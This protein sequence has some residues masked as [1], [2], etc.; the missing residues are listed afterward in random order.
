MTRRALK[1]TLFQTIVMLTV[2]SAF[3]TSSRDAMGESFTRR[4]VR[5]GAVTGIELGIEGAMEVTS[6]GRLRWL[7]TLYDIVGHDELRPATGGELRVLV[8]YRPDEPVAELQTDAYGRAQVE[9]DVPD[10]RRSGFNVVVQAVSRAG[11]QRHFGVQVTT[12]PPRHVELYVDRDAVAPSERMTFFGRVLTLPGARPLAS[13]EVR[14][15]VADERGRP[16]QAERTVRTGPAGGFALVLRA[17]DDVGTL[18]VTARLDHG[19]SAVAS[20]VVRDVLPPEMVVT[21]APERGL[22]S[23]GRAVPVDVVVRRADGR[24]VVGA[25]ISLPGAPDT[26]RPPGAAPEPM[27]RTNAAGRVRIMWR[28]PA[29]SGTAALE[30]VTGRVSATHPGL[31]Q[32]VTEVSVR[33]VRSAFD[34]GLA[35]EGGTLIPGLPGRVFVRVVSADGTA[36]PEGIPVQFNSELLGEH[37]AETD[38]SGVAVIEATA[39]VRPGLAGRDRCGGTTASAITVRVGNGAESA[40]LERCLPVDPD[41]TIRVRLGSAVVVAGGAVEATLTRAARVARAPTLITLLRRRGENL[42]PLYQ[43]VVPSSTSQIE[44]T[45]PEDVVGEVVVRARPLVGA[46]R[47]EVR[48]GSALVWSTPGPRFA[49]DVTVARPPHQVSVA[50]VGSSD[51]ARRGVVLVLRQGEAEAEELFARLREAWDPLART[52][53]D[54]SRASGPMLLGL[55]AA[56]TPRDVAAPA[57]IRGRDV[58]TLPAPESP[59]AEGVLRDPW[60]ARARFVRGRLGLVMRALELYHASCIPDDVSNVGAQEGRG[61]T[62]NREVLEA[63]SSSPVLGASGARALSGAPLTIEDLETLDSSFTFNNMARRITR[64]R[65]L[66]VLVALREFVRDN[67]LDLRWGSQGDPALWLPQVVDHLDVEYDPN[68]DTG[69]RDLL[70]DG[71]GRPMAIRRAAGGRTRFQFLTPLPPGYELVSA[72]P[73]GRFGTAD[74]VFDPFARVLASGG[75]YAEAVA[76][77]DLLA[78]LNGVEL[79]QATIDQLAEVFSVPIDSVLEGAELSVSELSWTDLPELLPLRQDLDFF[80]RGWAPMASHGRGIT[81]F[82]GQGTPL[83]LSLDDEPRR[84]SVV[85]VVWSTSGG[86]AWDEVELTGGVPLLV[87]VPRV[88]RLREGESIDIPVVVAR[89]PEAPQQLSIAVESEGDVGASLAGG[90]ETA[91]LQFGPGDVASSL[92]RLSAGSVGRGAVRIRVSDQSGT[93]ARVVDLPLLIDDGGLLREQVASTAVVGGEGSVPIRVPRG[94]SA[95]SGQLIV[96]TPNGNTAG[97]PGLRHWVDHDPALLAWASVLSGREPADSVALELERS[98]TSNG[99]V[100]GSDVALS[101]A[102]AMVAW[103]AIPEEQRAAARNRSRAASWLVRST[104]TLNEATMLAALASAAG[105]LPDTGSRGADVLSAHVGGLRD[106][107]RTLFR[108]NRRDLGVMARGAGALL[109]IDRRDT[110]GRAM[111]SLAREHLIPGFRGGLVVDLRALEREEAAEAEEE[112]DEA[113]VA[114]PPEPDPRSGAEQLVATAALAIAASQTGEVELARQLGQGL[115]ARA[116]VAISLGGEPLFWLLAARSY[117]V[118]GYGEAPAVTVE[119]GGEAQ[120]VTLEDGVAVVALDLPRPGRDVDVEIETSGGDVMPLVRAVARY[121]RPQEELSSSAL[122]VSLEGD[123]GYAG[124][125]AALELTVTNGGTTAIQRPTVLLSLPSAAALDLRAID[126][127]SRAPGVVEV[128]PPDRRGVV[129]LLLS[130]IEARE[131]RVISLPIPWVGAGEVTGLS[132]AAFDSER[133]FE[134]DLTPPRELSVEWRQD[135]P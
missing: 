48:G 116:H 60:R 14:L 24:P 23:P 32:A 16:I 62:F 80:E 123:V 9:I 128:R 5:G 98:V 77:D 89:L 114:R 34:V 1:I 119:I 97:D 37:R 42:E 61:W 46:E 65:L 83:R 129:E 91:A 12:R 125:R 92:V 88:S 86:I 68:N 58:V 29:A 2:Q 121:S 55:L 4:P 54:P 74:D 134:L 102:C 70:F 33:V 27:I 69:S 53:T 43:R 38:A 133:S 39:E 90:G 25:V 28:P 112:E 52:L 20:A 118:F 22:T 7:M 76:E 49:V 100:A 10:D 57:V 59:A 132:V 19:E 122:R 113:I 106:E 66:N 82:Q 95:L 6:G 31:G 78:R 75:V 103:A 107:V 50:T 35:V 64:E 111:F 99:S 11:V 126:A 44:L 93:T 15:A 8:S 21:A 84:Y 108:S 109:L 81:D 47:Q 87:E 71:W 13:T 120:Q 40:N 63:V 85:T 104:S 18:S 51:E 135:A 131:E 73:D 45:V 72:G 130:S 3:L 56:R 127:I 110:R 105:G 117:G 79:G 115:A 67:E 30:D 101:T 94:A 96:T 41:A 36:A 124:E 17:P 26:S